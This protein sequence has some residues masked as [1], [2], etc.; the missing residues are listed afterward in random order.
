MIKALFLDIDGT[1]VSFRTHQI[2]SSAIEALTKAKDKGVRIY[3]STG[4]PLSLINNIDEIKHLIDGYIT[5]NGACCIIGEEIIS[6]TPI[7]REDVRRVIDFSDRIGFA[8]IGC[9][10]KRT[11]HVS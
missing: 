5:T 10:R 9:R 2:P 7:P 4:R 8:C 6:C 11:G 3:I 1:L